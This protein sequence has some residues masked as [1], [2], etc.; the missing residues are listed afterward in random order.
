MRKLSA[1]V[2]SV[3]LVSISASEPTSRAAQPDRHSESLN[4]YEVNKKVCDYPEQEDLST[5]EAAY[6]V[7]NR[8]MASGEEGAWRRISIKRIKERLPAAD[9]QKKEVKPQIAKERLNARIVEVRIFQ[10]RHAV[11]IAEV[12][13]EGKPPLFDGRIVELENGKWL[14]A[15]HSYYKTIKHARSTF[16]GYCAQYVDKPVRPKIDDPDSYLK[17]FVDFLKTKGQEPKPFVMKALAKYKVVIMGEIHHRPLY[18]A[19]SS[20]LVAHPDFAKHVG[21]IYMELPSNDQDLVDK[22]LANETCDTMP[23]IEMLRDMLWMGWPDQPMLDFFMSVWMANQNLEPGKS[24]RIALVDMQRPWEKIQK[25]EDWREYDVDRDQFMA[26]NIVRDM[27]DHPNEKR[28]RLFIV[29]VGHTALNFK[30]FEG[31]PVPMAGYHLQKQLGPDNV[32]AICQHQCAMTNWGRVDGRVCLGLFDSAFEAIG[33]KPIAFTLENGP[34]GGQPYDASPDRK[35]DSTY[36]DGFNAYLYLGPPEYEVFSPLIAGFYTDDFVKEMDRRYRLMRGKGLVEGCRLAR[37]DS[38]SF[39]RWMSSWGKPRKWRTQLGPTT[40]WHWGSN[41]KEEIQESKHKYALEHPE[42]I[43]KVAEDFFEFIRTADYDFFLDPNNI[44]AHHKFIEY[45]ALRAYTGGEGSWIDW[46]CT[47]FKSNPI[48]SVELGEVFRKNVASVWGGKPGIP[49][50]HYK[51]TL[52]DGTVLKGDL[53]FA[54]KVIYQRWNGELGVDWHLQYPDS[55]ES[56]EQANVE[57]IQAKTE[58]TSASVIEIPEP[59]LVDKSS[60]EATVISFTKAAA[61]GNVEDALACMLPGGV[62]YEDVKDILNAKPSSRKFFIK[63]MWESI[64]IDKPIRILGKTLIDDDAE[65]GWQCYFKEEFT[66]E[67]RTFKR[68]DTFELDAGLKKHGQYWLIDNI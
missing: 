40:A 54:Y 53:P 47:T 26:D 51:L 20:S 8:V 59:G 32:Y 37:L 27:R 39:I 5:P 18:W 41:W 2:I 64:D 58:S 1:C 34:F 23:V 7:I 36:R 66:M 31:S 10:G 35:V 42:V 28:N 62:D 52:Q 63:K 25:R 22:F 43:R 48:K 19:F 61:T 65:V 12:P 17:P 21:T 15:G 29:G 4:V 49:A 11:V 6:A 33:N 60:P 57:P 55:T 56:K 46:I 30:Y 24:L 9:A 14:N 67:G 50:I 3:L 45:T 16:A 38:E 44:N 68:G 13:R